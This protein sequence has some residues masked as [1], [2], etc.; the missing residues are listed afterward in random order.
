MKKYFYLS[1]VMFLISLLLLFLCK[2]Y[3]LS[4]LMIVVIVVLNVS[5]VLSTLFIPYTE[6]LWLKS[7]LALLLTV[8]YEVC[9]FTLKLWPTSGIDLYLGIAVFLL[10]FFVSVASI[11]STGKFGLILLKAVMIILYCS[12]FL[13]SLPLAFFDNQTFQVIFI[14]TIFIVSICYS[15]FLLLYS[16]YNRRRKIIYW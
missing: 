16:E 7:L 8:V 13:F 5:I 12:L 11:T 4:I 15:M 9:I 1:V 3:D 10:P 14:S 2:V 6:N